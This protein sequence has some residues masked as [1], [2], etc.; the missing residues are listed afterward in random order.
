MFHDRYLSST[1]AAAL[2]WACGSSDSPGVA[3]GSAAAED[4][5]APAAV[6]SS[7]ARVRFKGGQR[8]QNDLARALSLRPTE[9][10][11]ELGNL[12][13]VDQ[14]HTVALGGVDA[15]QSQILRPAPDTGATTPLAVER[16]ALSACSRRSGLD[17]AD[18]DRATL[19]TGL[20]LDADGNLDLRRGALPT[21]SVVELYRRALGREPSASEVSSLSE[22]YGTV[23]SERAQAAAE[24]W[25]TLVCFV[26]FTSTESLFY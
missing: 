11:T 22:L 26:I 6:A 16:V 5:A 25:A 20:S 3:A 17:F 9:V 14:V 7:S 1:L 4:A 24:T 15:Y 2:C 12:Q 10:C 18:P 21:G 13:C 8:L 19:W 23:R